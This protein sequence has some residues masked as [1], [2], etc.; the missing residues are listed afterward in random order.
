MLVKRVNVNVFLFNTL[1]NICN[2][3]TFICV[4]L[5]V[6]HCAVKFTCSID[7]FLITNVEFVSL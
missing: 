5:D 2:L 7:V 1:Y 6:F 4:C 3:C